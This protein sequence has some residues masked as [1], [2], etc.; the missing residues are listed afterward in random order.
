[1]SLHIF[2]P[3]TILL[4]LMLVGFVLFLKRK[5]D[6]FSQ[7]DAHLYQTMRDNG[8]YDSELEDTHAEK[9]FLNALSEKERTE[10]LATNTLETTGSTSDDNADSI[11]D[12]LNKR[13]KKTK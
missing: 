9:A 3:V 1:M 12:Y 7:E 10:L 8:Y 5:Q 2:I 4:F 6:K 11:N 13:K